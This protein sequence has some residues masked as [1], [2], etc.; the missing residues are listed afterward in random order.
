M[1]Q[2]GSTIQLFHWPRIPRQLQWL[3]F[4]WLIGGF[5]GS[6][7]VHSFFW[8]GI[9]KKK[10]V[11]LWKSL[12]NQV[13][14]FPIQGTRLPTWPEKTVRNILY[15]QIHSEASTTLKPQKKNACY[16]CSDNIISLTSWCW[17]EI[18]NK[19]VTNHLLVICKSL[20]RSTKTGKIPNTTPPQ[21]FQK[22]APSAR[23]NRATKEW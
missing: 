11:K 8:G 18:R 7:D 17:L 14:K 1:V 6:K 21:P 23:W 2:L 16:T 3:P 22:A 12:G 10:P 4:G 19:W 20:A 13:W 5:W 9:A 15:T